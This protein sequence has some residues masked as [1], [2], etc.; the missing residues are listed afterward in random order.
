[1]FH[2]HK[3]HQWDLS[4]DAYQDE[5]SGIE[6]DLARLPAAA[7]RPHLAAVLS[8]RSRSDGHRGC[9]GNRTPAPDGRP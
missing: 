8:K 5:R 7:G 9:D 2:V 3:Q 6:A 1:M 4:D